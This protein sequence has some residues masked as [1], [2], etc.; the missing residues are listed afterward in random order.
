[1]KK[2]PYIATLFPFLPSIALAQT[3]SAQGLIGKFLA[4]SNSTLIPFALGIAFLLFLINVIRFFVIQGAEED[5]R[6]NAK[7]LAI[8]SV[9]AFV[10]LIIFWG[11]VNLLAGSIGLGGKSAP[12]PD[13][14][15]MNDVEFTTPSRTNSNTTPG[16]DSPSPSNLRPPEFTPTENLPGQPPEFTP[17]EDL[18]PQPPP[19]SDD[20]EGLPEESDMPG[21]APRNEYFP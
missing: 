8:Y 1:M 14:V 20:L 16:S 11:V 6:E 13:Y 19:V 4:F 10:T 2:I 5:G 15:K 18:P 12:T 7:N 17:S 21:F 3:L 9:L